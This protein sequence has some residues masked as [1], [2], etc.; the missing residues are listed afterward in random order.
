M[1]EAFGET[2]CGFDCVGLRGDAVELLVVPRLGAKVISLIN[3][4]TGRQWLWSSG[5]SPRLFEVVTG[6]DFADGPL[7]GADECVPT[8]APCKWNGRDLP[9]HGEAWTQ[10]WSLDD[11][12]LG[13]ARIV[14]RLDLPISPLS[15]ERTIQVDG[16]VVRFDYAIT[17]RSDDEQAY[18]WAFHPMMTIE[19]G[20]RIELPASVTRVRVEQAMGD[21]PLGARGDVWSWPTPKPGVDFASLDLGGPDRAVKL[22]TEPLTEGRAAIVNDR[23]GDRLTFTFDVAELN[24]LGIWINRGGFDGYQHVAL[25]P[26]NGAPDAL[27]LAVHDWK[28]YASV[29]AGAT[30][31]W[32]FTLNV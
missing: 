4:A 22:F 3:R 19:P 25:E 11:A 28:R 13:D 27:D 15:I 10:A 30:K 2:R 29:A 24:T 9:D 20:D 12:A 31:R 1:C 17:N 16:D 14:T 5:R 32:G 6:C 8:V 23:T 18:V 26:T 7:L 21:L